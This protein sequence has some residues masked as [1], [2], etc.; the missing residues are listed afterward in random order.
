M[1]T[2]YIATCAALL[3]FAIAS[4]A[5]AQG[6]GATLNAQVNASVG[7]TTAQGRAQASL[8]L[9]ITKGKDRAQQEIQRRIVMLQELNTRVQAMAHVSA[10]EKSSIAVDVQ[11][12]VQTLTLLQAKIEADTDLT[13][14]KADIKSI[15]QDYRVFML[16]IPQG[17]IEVAADRIG[18]VT[19]MLTA[20]SGKLQTRISAAQ[21][22]G[23]DVTALSA[24]LSDMNA[25]ITD[26]QTQAGAA[27]SVV[28]NL[29]PDQGDQTVEASNN[30]AL[31]TARA[32]IQ[33]AMQDLKTARQDAGTIVK[34][35][36]ALNV[37]AS[38]SASASSSAQQ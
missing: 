1:N 9:R 3:A 32:D 22:A 36:E 16:V 26:A 28:A 19:S 13:T 38:G 14:L 17:R 24:S 30:A 25:K 8:Q 7:S 21:T 37:N 18:T 5:F 33:A 31:K 12:E 35:L 11:N 34:G 10:N 4:P 15:V 20:F 29:K 6:V 2:K 23:K 27:A